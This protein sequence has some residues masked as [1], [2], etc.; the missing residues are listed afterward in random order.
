MSRHAASD[1][2]HDATSIDRIHVYADVVTTAPEPIVTT[3]LAD[4]I[5]YRVETAI[6]DGLYPP[7]SRLPQDE[8]CERFAVS[9]TPVREA[10]RKLQAKNLVL[11]VPNKGATVRLLSRKEL[12]NIYDVRAELEGH[13]CELAAA[14]IS[15]RCVAEL[16]Q[17]QAELEA[18]VSLLDLAT[19][20]DA[21][22][23][24]AQ[25]RMKGANDWFHA[26]IHLAADNAPLLQLIKDLGDRCPKDYISRALRASPEM[27]ALNF[28][29]HRRI[30][31][32][33]GAGDGQAARLAMREHIMHAR[34]VIV[35]YLDEQG[36]W[37][38]R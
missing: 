6:L 23:A 29:E 17:A 4:E 34:T 36:F 33:L 20:G 12:L 30:R 31:A 8:L 24:T 2:R 25:L 5:A 13:S 1:P 22:P 9:R 37:R 38:E 18:A 27:R 21:D 19:A 3:G 14:R 35:R 16:D 10:L 15:D 28:D 26:A 32:A 11:V 7:G